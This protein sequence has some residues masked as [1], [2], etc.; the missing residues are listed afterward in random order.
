MLFYMG[1]KFL[2]YAGGLLLAIGG[3]AVYY[4]AGDFATSVKRHLQNG[5][6][7]MSGGAGSK[8]A[9]PAESTTSADGGQLRQEVAGLVPP[10]AAA[11]PIEPASAPTLEEV[12]RFDVTVEWII[13]RWP[14]VSAGLPQLQLQGYR[15]PLVTGTSVRDLAGSL[16]YY[17][18]AAQQVQRITLTGKTGDPSALTTLLATRYHFVRRLTNDPSLVLYEA[19][20]ERN[21]PLG[22]LTIQAAKVLQAG[23]PH[24][25]FD[26]DLWVERPK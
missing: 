5:L 15:V 19:V 25:R 10:V 16:T 12:L 7:A 13:Q 6:A 3:P 17:F 26:I 18:N 9:S 20:D 23:Q 4:S 8:E 11:S 14:R 2:L 22:K 1:K 21:Q 24:R